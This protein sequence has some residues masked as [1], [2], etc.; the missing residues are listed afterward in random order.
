MRTNMK[1]NDLKIIIFGIIACVVFLIIISLFGVAYINNSPGAFTYIVDI[2]GLQN[3]QPTLITDVI[4]PLPTTSE[5]RPGFTD[6][7][8]QFKSFGEWRSM[9]VMTPYGKMLGF[10][11]IGR[12]LT[13]IHAIFSKVYSE[14]IRI[15]NYTLVS[16]SPD[17]P[18]AESDYTEWVDGKDPA[19]DYSTIIY[20][21]DSIRSLN[22]ENANITFSLDLGA[23]EGMQHSIVGKHYHVIVQ[24]VIPSGVRNWTR[25]VAQ[26]D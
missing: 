7:D 19:R 12:N 10:Q 20:I 6:E 15:E 24:E 23:S 8:F 5:E 26:V 13:D 4:I 21:P 1:K 18:F 16:L 3:Y 11:S 9:L 22:P 14:G 17:L 25:V 2:E